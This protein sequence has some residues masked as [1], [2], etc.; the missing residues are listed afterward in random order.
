MSNYD[1]FDLATG[2]FLFIMT[3]LLLHDK[4]NNKAGNIL[5]DLIMDDVTDAD[6]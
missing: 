3:C 2:C 6:Y 4:L 1:L 5:T